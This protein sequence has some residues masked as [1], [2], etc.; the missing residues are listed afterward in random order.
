[1]ELQ[2]AGNPASER[3]LVTAADEAEEL[4]A[5]AQWIRD[6]LNTHPEAQV[7]VIVPGLEGERA[8]VDRI[9]RE[10]L[11]PELEQI[12]SGA[13]P[14]EF[15]VGTPLAATP[16]VLVAL[17]LLQWMHEALPLDRVSRLLL[18]PYFADGRDQLAAAAAF[19][20][21]SLRRAKMLRP[22]ISLDATAELVGQTN[23]LNKVSTALRQM[24]RVAARR[25]A[26]NELLTHAEWAEVMREVLEAA[27]WGAGS[28]EDSLEF[29]VR[30]KWES[31]LDELATL[32]FDGVRVRFAEALQS[33]GRITQRMLFA[34]ESRQTPVQVMGPLEAAGSRFDAVWF[35]RAG[36]LSW[37]MAASTTPLLPWG[38]QRELGMPGDLAREIAFARQISERI[39]ASA[40]TVVFSYSS[41]AGEESSKQRMSA[42]LDGLGLKRRGVAEFLAGVP[43]REVVA[44][45][46]CEE[47]ARLPALPDRVIRGGAALLAAQAACG[48]KAFAEQRL[49]STEPDVA[50]LGM[51]A[52]QRGTLVHRILELFWKNVK[53]QEE[54]KT[55]TV[56]EREEALDWCIRKELQ[57]EEAEGA[58]PWDIAYIDMERQRLHTLLGLWLELEMERAPFEVKLSEKR[59]DDVRVGPLRLQVIVDRVDL[60]D[61]GGGE[62]GEAATEPAE[63]IVDYKTGRAE[64]GQWLTERPDA[65]QLPLY[66][67][68]SNAPRIAGVAFAK[69]R[70]GEEMHLHGYATRSEL[71]TKFARLK[72]ASTLEAQVEEWRRVLTKLANEFASGDVR[73]R[74]KQYPK[75]CEHCAQRL[76]CR[77]DVALMEEEYDDEESG[78]SDE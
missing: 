70:L 49:W 65:P 41:V 8:E 56:S 38:M 7:G 9:F 17:D 60:V 63:M 31:A 3:L 23:S 74:P 52:A 44:T 35:L 21:F 18:S 13:G 24:R 26:Q 10:I 46:V 75:T 2:V 54:L 69:V 20:A 4:R 22:E 25:L 27:D 58:T 66:A 5:C 71:V 72:E 78:G 51:D 68:L 15:S 32:D 14:Y 34:P 19:D 67:V 64:P 62:Q 40:E 42:A 61:D 39:T 29:Q 1:M 55:M 76:V 12:S 77:L 45:E 16:L 37:P 50:G 47:D 59:F 30:A 43:A 28:H 53:T 36:E 48:F 73:V 6:L 11:A 57:R 33:V